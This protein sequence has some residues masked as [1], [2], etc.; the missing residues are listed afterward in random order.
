MDST[1]STGRRFQDL[2]KL[3]WQGMPGE[4]RDAWVGAGASEEQRC[5]DL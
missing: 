5:L 3:E 1:R 4:L 2:Y